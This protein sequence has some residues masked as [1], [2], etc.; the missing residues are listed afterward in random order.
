MFGSDGSIGKLECTTP[1]LDFTL[2]FRC[3]LAEGGVCTSLQA[4]RVAKP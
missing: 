1:M 2:Q 4:T 3:T